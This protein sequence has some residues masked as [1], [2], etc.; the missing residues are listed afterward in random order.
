M[1]DDRRTPAQREHS[2]RMFTWEDDVAR[3]RRLKSFPFALDAV[4]LLRREMWLQ[5]K[6]DVTSARTRRLEYEWFRQTS[7]QRPHD[8]T[9]RRAID[10]LIRFDHL[11]R[12]SGQ[13]DGRGNMYRPPLR[14][15]GPFTGERPSENGPFTSE[16]SAGHP[17]TAG[18]LP[19]NE[20]VVHERTTSTSSYNSSRHPLRQA[21]NRTC[22]ADGTAAGYR[23]KQGARRRQKTDAAAAESAAVQMLGHDGYEVLDVLYSTAE[24]RLLYGRII[25]AGRTGNLTPELIDEARLTFARLT[26]NATTEL[27]EPKT[28]VA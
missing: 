27:I 28:A 20:G 22:G 10:A 3:D 2:S 1:K 16:R 9:V 11:E 12:I 13:A 6:D 19:M 4:V 25:E 21:T 8:S 17:R 14:L 15:R 26:A 18:R 23:R 5:D 24:G 7:G